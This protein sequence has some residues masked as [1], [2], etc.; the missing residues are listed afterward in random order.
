MVFR[1][2]TPFRRP[3][4][5]NDEP[6]TLPADPFFRLQHEMNQLFDDAF[7]GFGGLA[8]GFSDTP[9]SLTPRID[10]KETDKTFKVT[11]EL[12]GVDED[13]LH[14][15]LADNAL[16][17]SGEKKVE[18]ER[19]EKGGYHL[20]ERAY[21]AFSRTIPLGFEVDPDAVE[22]HFKNGVLTIEIPKP[23]ELET[24]TK[25]IPIRK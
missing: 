14:V 16:T 25:R 12:P 10:I 5:R 24:R 7:R 23:A 1:A 8:R 21:G 15:D 4:S 18:Q 22:A 20:M 11:V 2:L 3:N 6:A 9:A 19:D 17:I 13:D